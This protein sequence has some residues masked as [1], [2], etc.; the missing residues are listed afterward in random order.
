[1][2]AIMLDRSHEDRFTEAEL[3]QLSRLVG[4]I[5]TKWEY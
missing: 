5:A 2:S 3:A 1:M 4:D